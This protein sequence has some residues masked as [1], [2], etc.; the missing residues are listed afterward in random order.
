MNKTKQF[1]QKVIEMYTEEDKSTYEIAKHLNTYPNKVR[2]TLIKHG[3]ELKSKS[4]AQKNAL[5]T[6]RSYHPTEGK[7]RSSKEK[8]NISKGM[9]THWGEM[10]KE[11]RENRINQAK[12]RW[13]EMDLEQKDKMSRLAIEAIRKAG[14]EGSKLEKFVVERLKQEGHKVDFHNKTLIPTEKLEIDIYL[15]ELRTIIEV[16]GPSHFLPIWGEEKLQKQ[17]KADLHKSGLILSRGYAIIRVKA[18]NSPNLNN[19]EKL[20]SDIISILD[21]IKIDFPPKTKRF[22]EVEL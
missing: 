20:A 11:Q 3:F 7:K 19:K 17:I 13:Q 8:L 15:P 4:E 21:R 18:M 12:E 2:R 9:V 6:G 16:D 22:I 5:K 14:K 1:D 10:T